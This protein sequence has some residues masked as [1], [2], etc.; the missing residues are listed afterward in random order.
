MHI[1]NLHDN[2]MVEFGTS[3]AG[4]SAMMNR[5]LKSSRSRRTTV[6]EAEKEGGGWEGE[7]GGGGGVG[8]E[9]QKRRGNFQKTSPR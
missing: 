4:S 5:L 7:Q 2:T 6:W 9:V 1:L 8:G 3:R